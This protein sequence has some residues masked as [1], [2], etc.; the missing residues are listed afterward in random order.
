MAYDLTPAPAGQPPARRRNAV[1]EAL[2]LFRAG[3]GNARLST[4]VAFLYLCENEGLC[5]SELAA[6]AGMTLA[7][8][9]R[10]ARSLSEPG[11]PGAL[12]PAMGLAELRRQGKVHAL[13]L[14]PAGRALRA[15]LDATIVQATTIA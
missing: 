15:R 14:T 13:Y 4:V 11:E 10:A 8:A 9:S 12:A 7:T 5:I 1:L 3:E 6:A 2:E